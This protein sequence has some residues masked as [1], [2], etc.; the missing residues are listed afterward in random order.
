MSYLG[1]IDSLDAY[2]WS[3]EIDFTA[4]DAAEQYARAGFRC[5]RATAAEYV[6]SNMMVRTAPAFTPVFEFDKRTGRSLGLRCERAHSNNVNNSENLT[7]W[8]N[9]YGGLPG[10]AKGFVDP[11]GGNEAWSFRITNL[12]QGPGSTGQ[13]MGGII[14][15]GFAVPPD[16]VTHTAEVWV[17]C[18]SVRPFRFGFSDAA[19]DFIATTEWQRFRFTDVWSLAKDQGRICQLLFGYETSELAAGVISGDTRFYIWH[20]GMWH[21]STSMSYVRSDSTIQSVDSD[22]HYADS[23]PMF[24]GYGPEG[25]LYIE[26]E[27]KGQTANPAAT[28]GLFQMSVAGGDPFQFGIIGNEYPLSNSVGVL[29]YLGGNA[30]SVE[31]PL[32]NAGGVG[33][34]GIQRL[35]FGWHKSGNNAP[36]AAMNNQA[37]REMT[38]TTAKSAELIALTRFL[39]GVRLAADPLDGYIRKLR[40]SR[41]FNPNV[42]KDALPVSPTAELLSDLTNDRL[43]ST[44]DFS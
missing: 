20:P 27:R 37:F 6:D 25:A 44:D 31:G 2:P 40:F 11:A 32:R 21:G 1:P 15:T 38:G 41:A 30:S 9:W 16:G 12:L 4:G 39:L 14:N 7:A 35:A 34:R 18:D 23:R 19:S 5:P 29:Q 43:L 26:W 8:V 17:R 42:G 33:G 3:Y 22:Y 24:D 28:N 36:G 13:M 10:L